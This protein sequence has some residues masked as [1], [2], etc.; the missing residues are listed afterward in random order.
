MSAHNRCKKRNPG[1]DPQLDAALLN[2]IA[3]GGKNAALAARRAGFTDREAEQFSAENLKDPEIRARLKMLAE[4]IMEEVYAMHKDKTIADLDEIL[5]TMTK[6]LRDET[7]EE[8]AFVII[9]G[10]EAYVE[11]QRVGT[12]IKHRIEAANILLKAQGLYD[13]SVNLQISVPH[14]CG[15]ER[16]A[17]GDIKIPLFSGEPKDPKAGEAE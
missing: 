6:I 11:K 13:N 8:E 2:Y 4:K 3:Q 14:F 17:E 10:S 7:D 1:F 15:E 12:K 9:S 16:L 5:T